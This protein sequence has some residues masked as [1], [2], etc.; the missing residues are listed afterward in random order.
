[1]KSKKSNLRLRIVKQDKKVVGFRYD[2]QN[3]GKTIALYSDKPMYWAAI[4]YTD[5]MVLAD[6]FATKAQAKFYIDRTENL[7]GGINKTKVFKLATAI[8]MKADGTEEKVNNLKGL[9]KLF[10]DLK[11]FFG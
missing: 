7:I 6:G 9:S 11:G 2:V 1:M 10:A 3:E 8:L 4:R 5:K